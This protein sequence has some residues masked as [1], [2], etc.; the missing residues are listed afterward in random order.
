MS[1]PLGPSPSPF[2]KKVYCVDL[3]PSRNKVSER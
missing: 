3:S 1:I 2:V